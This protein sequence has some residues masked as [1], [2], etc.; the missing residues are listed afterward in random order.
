MDILY[1]SQY[2][3]PEIG[4]PAVRVSQLSRH[5]REMGHDAR[6]LTGFPHHPGGR[7]Y[8]S[9][10]WRFW[11]GFENDQYQGVPVYRA[12]LYP[13]PNRGV[14]RR[15]ASYAS[16]LATS[17]FRGCLLD[18]WPDVVIG[19]SPQLLA[20]LAASWIAGGHSARFVFEVRD[21]W[22]ESLVAVRACTEQ[23]LLY[24]S[25][26]RIARRLY[27][28]AWKIVVVTDQFQDRLVARGVP[29]AR[30]AVV[31]NGVDTDRFHPAVPPVAFP[32]LDG[33]FVVSYIG[34]LGMAHSVSTFLEAAGL[35]RHRPD[36]HFLIVG[37]G[38]ERDR[39]LRMWRDQHLDNL[40]FLDQQ[41]WE[42]IP[43]Y[44]TLSAASLVHLS[45]SPLFETVLP[46]KMFEI[47]AAGRPV[48]LGVRGEAERLLRQAE[49]GIVCEPQSAPDL[50]RA[51]L[52]LAADPA[53][54]Q[55]LGENGRDY[56]LRH[57]S[58]RQRAAEYLEVLHG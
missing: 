37:N 7:L 56:V 46:S 2:F 38:A 51:I 22:P 24:R 44:L 13:T 10:R 11:K 6:V 23:S 14:V 41:P 25:L 33:K 8:P 19:S 55:R 53:L 3:P 48:I 39:L 30:I 32:Q 58:Y 26:D 15:S 40:T 12:W 20:A 50:A 47:M 43:S 5:F 36:I 18:F 57:A 34:T 42:A 27:R 1:V 31:K 49:A 35:L 28:D 54:C 17:T 45:R 29:P 21:L 52:Q 16:F 4:A 9:Y